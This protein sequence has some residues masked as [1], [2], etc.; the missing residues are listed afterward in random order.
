MI[1]QA[2]VKINK[3]QGIARKISSHMNPFWQQEVQA[4]FNVFVHDKGIKRAHTN[5]HTHTHTCA[6]RCKLL[7]SEALIAAPLLL[8]LISAISAQGKQ[9]DG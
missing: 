4:V 1:N 7:V 9:Q 6:L 2:R 3:A 8:P 5:T